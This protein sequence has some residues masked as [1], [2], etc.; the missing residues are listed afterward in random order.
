MGIQVKEEEEAIR[1]DDIKWYGCA[2]E[3][4]NNGDVSDA[5]AKCN[6]AQ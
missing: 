4:Y 5:V 2:V 3:Y 6:V 1:H